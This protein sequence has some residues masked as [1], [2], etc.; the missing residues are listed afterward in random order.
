VASEAGLR[1]DRETYLVFA[2][3]PTTIEAEKGLSP[4]VRTL[5]GFQTALESCYTVIEYDFPKPRFTLSLH[6]H[7]QPSPQLQRERERERGWS[8]TE[9]KQHTN[10]GTFP[11]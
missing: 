2:V 6:H 1:G 7:Q 5:S 4:P 9:D 11:S 8:P 3:P 10:F